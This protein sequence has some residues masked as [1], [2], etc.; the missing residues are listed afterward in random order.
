MSIVAVVLAADSGQGFPTP[1]YLSPF[2]DSTLL[3]AVVSDAVSWPV[4][5]VIVVLGSDAEAIEAGVDL[6]QVSVLVDPQWAE[7]MASPMRASLDL[8]SR[9]RSVSHVLVA[10]GDQPGITADAVDRIITAARDERADAVVPK[11]RYALGWP[12]IVSRRL[13]DVFLGLEGDIDMHGL[14]AT[15]ASTTTEVWFDRLSPIVV[16]GVDDLPS[17]RR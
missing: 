2:H 11:Y 3:A 1:K 16:D 8:I 9:D 15:H 17:A 10:R 12:V 7:G 13:W 4:D 14:V 5:E 6:S